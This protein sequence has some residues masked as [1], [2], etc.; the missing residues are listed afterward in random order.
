MR[1]PH[2]VSVR[3]SNRYWLQKRLRF[4]AKFSQKDVIK[5][6]LSMGVSVNAVNKNNR[7]ALL[8]AVAK[9]NLEA[10]ELLCA[11]G[12]EV[13]HKTNDILF[14][15]IIR[16]NV[17]MIIMLLNYGADID[18]KD[19]DGF[20]CIRIACHAGFAKDG[21]TDS[22]KYLISIGVDL[23]YRTNRL[24]ITSLRFCVQ[25]GLVHHALVLLRAGASIINATSGDGKSSL[26]AQ[27]S[28]ST[29]P[30][31]E[32]LLLNFGC[33]SC[34]INDKALYDHVKVTSNHLGVL[35]KFYDNCT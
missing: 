19:S 22:L 14:I 11:N 13:Q 2:W 10:A 29:A 20:D 16:N 32:E 7:S 4:A 12:A 28:L 9:D 21:A 5:Q 27:C 18:V 31:A 6:L 33:D 23:E 8:H 26:L 35:F 15:A 17:A 34:E 30:V 1:R 25:F 24:D 3:Y